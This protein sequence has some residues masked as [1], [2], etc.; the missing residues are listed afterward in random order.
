MKE[1]NRKTIKITDAIAHYDQSTKWAYEVDVYDAAGEVNVDNKIVNVGKGFAPRGG[2]ILKN[3]YNH[4]FRMA[5]DI[6]IVGIYVFPNKNAQ[7]NG[8]KIK[9]LVLGPPDFIQLDDNYKILKSDAIFDPF[10]TSR[11][12]KN[13]DKL[14]YNMDSYNED[15]ES[16]ILVKYRSNYEMFGTGSGYLIVE[17]KF[18]FTKYDDKPAHEPSGALK[19]ARL[20]PIIRLYFEKPK[21]D[22]V[23]AFRV[24]Y[25]FYLNLDNWTAYEKQERYYGERRSFEN[26]AVRKSYPGKINN[27]A[28][29]FKDDNRSKQYGDLL[30]DGS[31]EEVVFS[32]AEKPLVAELIAEGLN[33]KFSDRWYNVHWWGAGKN[34]VAGSAPG[35][36]HAV[37]IHWKWAF[38]IQRKFDNDGP[39]PEHEGEE[40]FKGKGIDGEL[41]DPAVGRQTLRIAIVKD[42][43]LFYDGQKKEVKG[44]IYNYPA[45]EE[46]NKVFGDFFKAINNVPGKISDGE[47][48]VLYYSAEVKLSESNK[49]NNG[50][51]DCSVFVHGLFFAHQPE[52]SGMLTGSLGSFYKNPKK[53]NS[54]SWT[55]NPEK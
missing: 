13:F 44:Y 23:E 43:S 16:E 45:F 19:A 54:Q 18:I 15:T 39:D 53:P 36:F 8:H 20:H 40:P 52:K 34:W 26:V 38:E 7:D 14:G 9:F 46:K 33:P 1:P 49:T 24:D 6:G 35:S 12:K 17:Q 21:K 25:R 50:T 29:V 48:I 2:I 11:R 28:G 5:Y 31:P 3:V 4:N 37:H 51:L 32:S 10:V 55:R 30:S 27:A 22:T 47:D 42:N 41:T